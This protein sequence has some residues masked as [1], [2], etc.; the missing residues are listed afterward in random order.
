MK[1]AII[2]ANGKTGRLTVEKAIAAGHTVRALVR[3]PTKLN[4][5]AGVEVVSGD[6][7]DAAAVDRVLQGCD[8]AISALGITGSQTSV[9]STATRLV[10][11]AMPAANVRRYVTIGG[12]GLDMPGDEKDL[13]GKVISFL[14]RHLSPAVFNDKQKE[15]LSLLESNVDWIMARP[16]RLVDGPGTGK[17]K[18]SLLRS[19]GIK[20]QRADLADFLVQA[21]SNDEFVRRAPFVA[22]G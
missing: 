13:G 17:F 16:P 1:I 11:K 6:A 8:A 22:S 20:I 18:T 12:A 10:L 15:A 21:V 5:P 19:P 3:D 7:N 4:A 14:V 9:C 2:G